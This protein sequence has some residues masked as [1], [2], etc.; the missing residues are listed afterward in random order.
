MNNDGTLN[1]TL[2]SSGK[3]FKNLNYFESGGDAGDEYN[4]GKP[5]KD[6]VFTTLRKKGAHNQKGNNTF[7]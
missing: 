2:K 3:T 6:T 5:I 1:V 4:F 7:L